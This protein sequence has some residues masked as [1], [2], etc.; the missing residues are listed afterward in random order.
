MNWL[1]SVLAVGALLATAGC[2][3]PDFSPLHGPG[4]IAIYDDLFSISTTDGQ[5]L[6]AV[7]FF[8]SAYVSNDGGAN[9]TLQETGTQK[10][11]YD[12]S[13]ADERRGWAVGQRGLILRTED[14]GL[15]WQSQPN[16]KETQGSQLFSVHAV[17]ANTAW[18]VG[19]WGTRLFTDD[20]GKTWQ[21][22]SLTIDETHPRFVWLAPAEQE[23][24]RRGEK[25]FEDV[26]LND[27]F[28]LEPP[29]Q[30]CWIVGEFGYVFYSENLGLSWERAEIIGEISMDPVKIPY[31]ETD[32]TDADRERITAFAK[33]IADQNHLNIDVEPVAL[34]R[35]IKEFGQEDDPFELFEI[36]DARV[37]AVREVL[38][39]AGIL[40]D[41]IR[42][43]NGPPWDY[44]DF[45][46]DDPGFLRRYLDERSSEFAG[47]RVRVAQNPYLFTVDF[48]DEQ[49]GLISGLG[50]VILKSDDG[51]RTWGYRKTDRKQALFSVATSDDI[52][53]AVGEKGLV[54]VSH[55]GGDTWAQPD[56]GFPEFFTFMRNVAFAPDGE[57]GFIVGQGGM[58]LKTTDAGT[59]WEQ[60]LPPRERRLAKN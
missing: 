6:V 12:V 20:G 50:G 27:V 23:M 1:R 37:L 21:D 41:R 48:E 36:L 49:S 38:E 16:D 8:G 22:R 13:M 45:L 32:I 55:D 33:V 47:I 31:N 4:E 40:S 51:G 11:L 44:E 57:E 56:R 14:G 18:V 59:N 34:P 5:H 58:I 9:W 7:G 24:V 17:D 60:I 25:V 46:E 15:S 10:S 29:S 53:I 28:C 30:E 39:E 26:G 42:T 52:A 54:Q 43:R 19:E 2:H 3:V 35:E